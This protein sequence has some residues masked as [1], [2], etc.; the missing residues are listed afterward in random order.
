MRSTGVIGALVAIG[1]SA[2]AA[3]DDLGYIRY[4]DPAEQAFAVSVPAGWA[5]GGRMVRY[6][7]ISIAPF[8]QAMTRDGTIFVQLGDWHVKDYADIP[9]WAEGR[10]YTPG[11]SVE[12]VRRVRTAEQ[13]ARSYASTF[14]KML[15]CGSPALGASEAMPAPDG[16]TTVIPQARLETS[17]AHFTCTRDGARFTGQVMTTVQSYPLPMGTVAWNIVYLASELSR[18]DRAAQGVAAWNAMRKSFTFLPAW[19]AHE[20]QIAAEAVKPAERQL[21]AT[22]NQAQT[23]DREIL[24]GNVLVEDPSTGA[25]SEISMG[26]APYYF[27]D[28]AGHYYNSYDPMARPG[29]HAVKPS[30]GA[31]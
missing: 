8:V 18:E 23:F 15:D 9:G 31:Q 26:V 25:H 24:N 17:I 7:P 6:G 10:L 21:Q 27:S 30:T 19:N 20:S 3:A 16:V 28:G 22:L 4:V 2:T 5:T 14:A 11:T 13:Y 12:F 29:F 1:L